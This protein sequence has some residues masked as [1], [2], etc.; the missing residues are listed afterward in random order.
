ME[1]LDDSSGVRERGLVCA[2]GQTTQNVFFSR[3]TGLTVFHLVQ[4]VCHLVR[5]FDGEKLI[6]QPAVVA[7]SGNVTDD[8]CGF[9]GG[10]AVIQDRCARL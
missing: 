3:Y 5:A 4:Q 1:S 2:L 7:V 10:E 8:E 6:L 9:T